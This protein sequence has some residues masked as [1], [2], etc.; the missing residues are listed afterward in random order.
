MWSNLFPDGEAYNLFVA[1]R[2]SPTVRDIAARVGVS[3]AAVSYALA[4]RSSKVS[5]ALR[6]R[7]LQAAKDLGYH[8]NPLARALVGKS[9]GL[10]GIIVRDSSAPTAA[11]LCHHLMRKAPGYDYDIV[12]TDAADNVATLLR[13]GSLMKSRLCDGVVLVGELPQR[14][15]AWGSYESLGIPTIALL[16]DDATWPGPRVTCDSAA[17]LAQA[18]D[19]LLALGHRRIAYVGSN[20]LLGVKNRGEEFRSLLRGRGLGLP[21]ELYVETDFSEQGGQQ[22][23]RRLVSLGRPPSAIVACA[24]RVALGILLEAYHVGLRV[25]TDLSIVGFDD[26]RQAALCYPA[27]T[28]VRQPLEEM[29]DLALRWFQSGRS[30]GKL[31]LG[32]LHVISEL[33]IRQSTGPA[34]DLH[35]QPVSARPFGRNMSATVQGIM[36]N[37]A[38]ET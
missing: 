33:V 30:Q 16:Y 20:M 2:R 38:R 10:L 21:R 7:V 32:S 24:D 14:H 25:P 27:L 13:L 1:M 23:L 31:A 17:G 6:E 36:I 12:L 28:T 35:A 18:I 9:T 26:N 37:K 8:P 15:V 34:K 3:Q 22:A 4:G 19:H 29:A 5:R 11:E